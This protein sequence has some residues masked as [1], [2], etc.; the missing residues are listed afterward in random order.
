M[1][2]GSNIVKERLARTA[3]QAVT[4]SGLGTDVFDLAVTNSA[5]IHGL[6]QEYIPA[7]KLIPW[8]ADVVNDQL[9][10]HMHSRYFTPRRQ[11]NLNDIQE[12]EPGV[13]IDGQL[14]ELQGSNFVHTSDNVVQYL[15]TRKE[16]EGFSRYI[17][18]H[19]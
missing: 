17:N 4:L 14:K 3:R 7:G 16:S 1:S 11:A 12:F 9:V 2:N 6:F 10:L 15:G 5:K 13:D 8:R 18:H 19:L